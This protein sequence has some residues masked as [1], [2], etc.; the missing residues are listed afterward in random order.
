ME[1][2]LTLRARIHAFEEAVGKKNVNGIIGFGPCIRSTMVRRQR[3]Y[4]PRS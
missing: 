4:T 2:D 3:N 1:L